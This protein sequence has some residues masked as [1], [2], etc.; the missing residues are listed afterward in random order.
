[1]GDSCASFADGPL[2][3]A[4]RACQE[5]ATP[6]LAVDQAQASQV[7]QQRRQNCSASNGRCQYRA[8]LRNG[9]AAF[10]DPAHTA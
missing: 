2:S 8:E 9:C 6:V 4:G 1:V 7:A 3:V 5:A 10:P